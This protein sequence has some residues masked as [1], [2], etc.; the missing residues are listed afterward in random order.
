M[1]GKCVLH[2]KQLYL[3]CVLNLHIWN[4]F[5]STSVKGKPC[6]G[7]SKIRINIQ[8]NWEL[9]QILICNKGAT[10]FA[11]PINYSRIDIIKIIITYEPRREK[12]GFLHMQ[13]QRRISA[14]R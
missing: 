9:T 13:K 6:P 3:L 10:F 4:D 7:T 1:Y 8:P 12:T 2:R 11:T 5:V 14:S